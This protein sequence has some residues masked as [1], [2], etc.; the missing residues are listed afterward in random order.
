MLKLEN[1]FPSNQFYVIEKCIF[2]YAKLTFYIFNAAHPNTK[3]FITHGGLLSTQEAAF[4]GVPLIGIPF[5]GDQQLN[6]AKSARMGL[7]VALDFITLTKTSALTAIKTILD[8]P[9]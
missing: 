4:H 8:D 7:A 1:G 5:F 6:V 9:T 2:H 3:L